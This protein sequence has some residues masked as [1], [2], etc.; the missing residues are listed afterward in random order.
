MIS[1]LKQAHVRRTFDREESAGWIPPHAPMAPRAPE[2][3]V[4]LLVQ[5]ERR[6]DGF[7]LQ[8]IGPAPEFCGDHWYVDLAYAEHAAEELFGIGSDQWE[9]QPSFP[10]HPA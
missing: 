4:D 7:V 5:I 8:W 1:V 6:D 10:P 2:R 3:T 9:V